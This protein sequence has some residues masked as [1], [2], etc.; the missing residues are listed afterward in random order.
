MKRLYGLGWLAGVCLAALLAPVS[1]IAA[2]RTRTLVCRG[3]QRRCSVVVSIAGEAS[4]RAVAIELP[5]TRWRAPGVSVSPPSSRGAYAIRHARFTPAGSEY[6]FTLSV[7][8]SNPRAQLTLTFR[9]PA[10]LERDLIVPCGGSEHS[11]SAKVGLAGGQSNKLVIILL[12]ATG[13]HAPTVHVSPPSSQGKYTIR[14][15]MFTANGRHFRFT[16]DALPSN[17]PGSHLTL[18]FRR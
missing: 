15:R 17:P 2:P 10:L 14:N 12:P 11:C 16:L 6:S 4:T 1:A 13:F 18:T 5:G 8:R 3:S 9:A 7:P